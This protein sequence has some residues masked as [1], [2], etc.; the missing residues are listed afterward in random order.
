MWYLLA[1]KAAASMLEQIET[2]KKNIRLTMSPEQLV[3]AEIRAAAWV[4]D[5]NLSLSQ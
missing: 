4:R 5:K 1:E 2:G 3:E